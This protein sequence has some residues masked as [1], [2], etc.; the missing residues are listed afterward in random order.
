MVEE[1][2]PHL[3]KLDLLAASGWKDYALLDCGGGFKLEQFG[4]ARLIRPEPEAVWQPALSETEWKKADAVY[5]PAPEENGGHWEYRRKLPE[6]WKMS[7][8]DISFWVQTSASRH[9]GVFPEQSCQW[10]WAD[11]VIRAS[12]AKPKV[13]NLF[14]YTGLASL[15]AARAGAVVTH[16]DASRKVITW[17]NENQKLSGLDSLPIRWILDDAVK[18]VQRE[19]RRGSRYD[20][21]IL[22]PPK[23]GRGP[24][25]E[26]WEFYKLLPDLLDTCRQILSP[27]PLFVQLTAY[28]VK[29]SAATMYYAVDEMMKKFNGNT[30][31]GE[32]GLLEQSAGRY[33]STAIYARW[34]RADVISKVN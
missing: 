15:A 17:A 5:K 8:Q 6:H 18:F 33:L 2:S 13:L 26:V 22:D 20:G 9:L 19:N 23:F 24:K 31:A 21:I 28:A 32:I 25:G 14:G 7:Y 29:A 10:T 30:Y 4:Q 11:A 34:C 12:K 16:L 27:E 3:P 1:N